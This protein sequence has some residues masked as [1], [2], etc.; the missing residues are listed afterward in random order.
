[1]SDFD[2]N[3]GAEVKFAQLAP[4]IPIPIPVPVHHRRANTYDSAKISSLAPLHDMLATA[5]LLIVIIMVCQD[6]RGWRHVAALKLPLSWM[7]GAQFRSAAHAPAPA[8][9]L[10]C[11]KFQ[12]SHT[13]LLS[14]PRQLVILFKPCR[15]PN[16]HR[17]AA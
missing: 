5:I 15:R 10:P 7:D 1:L 8:P 13:S 3:L 12:R 9:C 17:H 14:C 2:P 6:D 11:V 16:S 4:Q